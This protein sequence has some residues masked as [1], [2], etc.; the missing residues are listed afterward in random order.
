MMVQI[1]LEFIERAA[2]SSFLVRTC[3]PAPL[4]AFEIYD[5]MLLWNLLG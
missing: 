1:H 2:D 5:D 3:R 4:L